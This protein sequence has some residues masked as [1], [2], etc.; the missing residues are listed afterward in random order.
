MKRITRVFAAAATALLTLAA[1]GSAQ[2]QKAWPT[3]PVRIVVPFAIGGSTAAVASLLAERLSKLWGMEVVVD[4]RGGGNT[5]IGTDLVAKSAPDG[6]TLLLTSNSHVI[7]P[8][9]IATTF[10]PIKD[11]APV[12]E[13]SVSEL[14]LLVNPSVPANNLAEFLALAKARP[15]QVNYASA[16]TSSATH[17]AAEQLAQLAGV[18]LQHIPYKGSGPAITDLLGGQ[19]QASFQVPIIGNPFVK[20]G[21]LRALAVTGDKRLA[22]TPDVPTFAEAGLPGLNAAT[23][24]G[25]LAPAGTPQAVVDKV[26]QDMERVLAQPEFRQRLADLGMDPLEGG[27]AKFEQ[28]IKTTMTNAGK[29]IKSADIK[30]E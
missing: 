4:P 3:K 7:I 16:G 30:L 12:G 2:A 24:F 25:V 15:G 26:S 5:V 18:K 21:K 10:D 17:M 11:F 9:L 29:V 8:Q 23:W 13:L 22:A 14:I 6:Y 28:L 1:S 27:P 20:S 19:V